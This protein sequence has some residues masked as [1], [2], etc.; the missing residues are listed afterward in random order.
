MPFFSLESLVGKPNSYSPLWWFEINQEN[1][2]GLYDTELDSLFKSLILRY[3]RFSKFLIIL[4]M[5]IH[6]DQVFLSPS[7]IKS[8]P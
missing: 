7:A 6:N 2:I 3:W 4:K 8:Y 5:E 1:N